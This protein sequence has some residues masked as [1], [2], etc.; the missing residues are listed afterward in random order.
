MTDQNAASL[1]RPN[2]S[3]RR[4]AL[5]DRQPH[6]KGCPHR[7]SAASSG[8]SA[9]PV[10]QWLEPAAH[11]G[12]V[13]GSSP[14][15]PTNTSHARTAISGGR[16][17][18][19]PSSRSVKRVRF[20]ANPFVRSHSTVLLRLRLVTSRKE[21]VQGNRC[22]GTDNNA[23]RCENP[24]RGWKHFEYCGRCEVYDGT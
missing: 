3:P 5:P 11:N 17:R 1:T 10:A 6:C 7:C 4:P 13:A 15:G 20:I 23:V 9:G 19:T 2:P 18:W 8:T 22:N 24:Y 16:R 14:A 21:K 12:L